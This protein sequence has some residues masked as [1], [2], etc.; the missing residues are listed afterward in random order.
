MADD[1]TLLNAGNY[2]LSNNSSYNKQLEANYEHN[3]ALLSN[4]QSLLPY[5]LNTVGQDLKPILYK[6]G[7][8]SPTNIVDITPSENATIKPILVAGVAPLIPSIRGTIDPN[9]NTDYMQKIDVTDPL[10]GLS[11]RPHL[12]QFQGIS[13]YLEMIDSDFNK[14]GIVLNQD[15]IVTTLK[16]DPNPE[17]LTLNSA[18]KTVR[19]T[20]LN[21]WVEEHWGDEI[22]T[23]AFTGSTF[24]FFGIGP[25]A[26][27]VGL[28]YSYRN[29]TPAYE[30]LK[31]LVKFFQMNGCL[32]HNGSDYDS[33]GY[34]AVMDFLNTN[35]EFQNNH[36]YRGMIKERLYL[37]LAYD[38]LVFLGRFESFDII[39][40]AKSPYR[41]TYNIIFKAEKTIYLLDKSPTSGTDAPAN[42]LQSNSNTEMIQG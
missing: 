25:D 39:E 5:A 38:Y 31:Q 12:K 4:S 28:T 18:K 34:L 16:I 13:M 20:T 23:V 41:F 35:P 11:I 24:S 37:R 17:S 26:P 29:M 7:I 19:F 36:P 9:Q 33:Q 10:D 14:K 42:T 1:L 22:D 27:D 30:Y 15:Y 8:I 40:D 2:G 21:R 32:Y 3:A 6:E